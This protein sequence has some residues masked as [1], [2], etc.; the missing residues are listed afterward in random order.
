MADEKPSIQFSERQ[1]AYLA[2]PHYAV[3]ATL[4]ADG[5][6]QLSTTWFGLEGDKIVINIEKESLK[7]RHIKRDPRVAI[8]IPHGGRYVAI[9]GRAEFD[10]NQDQTEAR[11]DLIKLGYRY[12]GSIEGMN[13]VESFGSAPRLTIYIIPEKITSVGV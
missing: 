12:Y 4:S 11:A 3:L 5:S 7:A 2:Y 6:P 13:Q 10:E 9:K 1:R 8:S